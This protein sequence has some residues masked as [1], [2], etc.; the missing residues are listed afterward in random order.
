MFKTTPTY[1]VISEDDEIGYTIGVYLAVNIPVQDIIPEK[2]ISLID[3]DVI[4]F[5]NIQQ[6]ID[7]TGSCFFLV[8]LLFMWKLF[9]TKLM[10]IVSKY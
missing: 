6:H 7:N 8:R 3:D 2:A 4:S 1:L 10:F 9:K 5:S